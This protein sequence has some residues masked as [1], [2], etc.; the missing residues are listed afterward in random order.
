MIQELKNKAKELGFLSIGFS[1]PDKPAFMNKFLNFIKEKRYGEMKWLKRNVHIRENPSLLLK[2]CRTII[3]L[4]YP[5]PSLKWKTE[6]GFT[7]SRYSHPLEEDY[8]I[9]IKRL[10]GEISGI[11]KSLF[12]GARTRLCVDSAPILERSFAYRSGMGFFGKNNMLII[13][14]YGSYFYLGEI[15][16]TAQ[17][18]FEPERQMESGCGSCTK[19]IENCPTGALI[20]PYLMDAGKCLSYLSIE[21]KG[22]I[23]HNTAKLMGNC[24]IGC[25]R[26]QEV[27]PFNPDSDQ[28]ELVLPH[29]DDILSMDEKRFNE[30][31]G[32]SALSRPGL[33]KIKQNLIA[34]KNASPK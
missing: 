23:D 29:S 12:K 26:C 4:A 22:Q 1:K 21:W 33:S 18:E 5:Y 30:L 13:P 6:D 14:G 31:F 7:V 20:G 27:C 9:R 15:L 28:G 24:F 19:C 25:D 34:I 3:S 2:D 11:I 32:R 10:M 8:H 17:I 16:T